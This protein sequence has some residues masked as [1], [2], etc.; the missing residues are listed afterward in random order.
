MNY[1]HLTVIQ[2]F[3]RWPRASLISLALALNI[4][5][6]GYDTGIVG[7]MS[8]L[9]E[10][11][12]VFGYYDEGE[13]D[14]LIRGI[15]LSLWAAGFPVGTMSGA[16]I[17]GQIQ[18][19]I[20][21]KSTLF[22]GCILSIGAITICYL[23]DLTSMPEGTYLAGK[24]TQGMAV[25]VLMC[26]VQTY[27]S[28]V[29]PGRLRGPIMA[30]FPAFQLVG[31]LLAAVVVL[32]RDGIEGRSAYRVAIASEYPL[33]AIP[34]VL[35]FTIPESPVWLLRKN[36]TAAAQHSFRK[37]HGAKCAAE[38]MDLFEDMNKAISEE[39]YSAHNKGASYIAC[40]R[41]TNL[42]RTIIVVFCNGMSEF[43][44][45]NLLGNVSYFLQLLGIGDTA[46][47]V[48]A[49]IGI[50][51]GLFANIAS[52]WTLS[53]FGRRTLILWTLGGVAVLWLSMGIAGC[54]TGIAVGW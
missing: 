33:S 39:R 38:H 32:A 13:K 8:S 14:Y 51:L 48:V 11:R 17:G 3:R 37:I 26:S 42:K 45:F 29:V 24:I 27:L 19:I 34:L 20:G 10:Y 35:A 23:A 15:W 1:E 4:L 40:F 43:M 36:K 28:E 25:G 21:R 6:W 53:K 2:A 49:I 18:D 47:F 5:L 46:S 7:G 12:K 41:G 50:L 31:Q 30:L 54:F 22:I 16:V 44:G 9:V 52:F